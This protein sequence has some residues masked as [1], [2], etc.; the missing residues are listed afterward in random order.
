MRVAR[1][2]DLYTWGVFRRFLSSGGWVKISLSSHTSTYQIHVLFRFNPRFRC[3]SSSRCCLRVCTTI[4][5]IV[6]YC[7]FLIIAFTLRSRIS[8][9]IFSS[10]QA[11]CKHFDDYILCG[12]FPQHRRVYAFF[13]LTGTAASN[14]NGTSS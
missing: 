4:F 12:F 2:F 10:L 3:T 9:L 8:S 6:F 1:P 14:I 13:L 5:I 11:A 7:I